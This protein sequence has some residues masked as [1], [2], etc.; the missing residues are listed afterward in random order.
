MTDTLVSD[1]EGVLLDAEFLEELAEHQGKKEK[2]EE[3]TRKGIKGKVDWEE[4]LKERVDVLSG[5]SYE[6]ALEVAKDLPYMEGARELCSEL[7]KRGFVLIGVTGG[8]NIF[9]DKVKEDL[10]LDYIISNELEFDG[11]CLEGIGD[12]NVSTDCIAGLEE[13]L[14]EVGK[15]DTVVIADGAN[16][17]K[18]FEYADKKVAFNA[19]PIVKEHADVVIESKDLRDVLEVIS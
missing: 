16:N 15:G 9:S 8:F 7:K 1:V 13:L 4:G 19:Q 6:A 12:L 17:L 11:G 18:L 14:D 2:V 3:I 5:V 10:G